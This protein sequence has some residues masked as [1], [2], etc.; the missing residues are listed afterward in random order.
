MV[1]AGLPA[2]TPPRDGDPLGGHIGKGGSSCGVGRHLRPANCFARTQLPGD[3][4]S[5]SDASRLAGMATRERLDAL[6]PARRAELLHVLNAPRPRAGHRVAE[7]SARGSGYVSE[8][9]RHAGRRFESE[10]V[11]P[12]ELERRLRAHLDALGPA[13]R[14]DLLHVLMLPDLER[15]ERIGEFWS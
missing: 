15:A 8:K 2:R 7:A 1:F 12:D 6:G 13:P 14:A 4:G 10:A 5:D 11:R 3:L 9:R